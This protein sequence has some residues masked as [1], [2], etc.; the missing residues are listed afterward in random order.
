MKV[1]L[2]AK[3][4]RERIEREI[5]THKSEYVIF[6]NLI[7]LYP[8]FRRQSRLLTRAWPWLRDMEKTYGLR[9]IPLRHSNA[10]QD[11]VK[12]SGCRFFHW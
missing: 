3:Q 12:P 9:F 10:K 6:D 11:P 8:G 4:W 2:D 1:G 7:S 5:S